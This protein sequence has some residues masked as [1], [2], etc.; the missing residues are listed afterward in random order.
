MAEL[1]GEVAPSPRAQNDRP[2][3]FSQ[4]SS[5]FSMSPSSPW[6]ASIRFRICTSHQVPSRHGVHL[7]Q[8]S[9]L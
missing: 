6:P 7:P 3:M 1:I 8:D 9:C 4:R 5:S 2:R